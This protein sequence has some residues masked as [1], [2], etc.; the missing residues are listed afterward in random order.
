MVKDFQS[1]GGQ[2]GY[3]ITAAVLHMLMDV[4]DGSLQN[5]YP[6]RPNIDYGTKVL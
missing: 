5:A 3:V 4:I 2:D 6:V 1:F